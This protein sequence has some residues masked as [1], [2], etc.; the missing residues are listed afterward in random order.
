M[1][2]IVIKSGTV[3]RELFVF[4][5]CF[6]FAFLMNVYAI[7]L[8]GTPWR[9]MFTQLGYVIVIALTV[10]LLLALI[11]LVVYLLI[12]PFQRKRRR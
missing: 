2:D 5:V 3:K 12:K 9:E 4:L 11:R 8:A 6:V 10:Y 7:N 1:K